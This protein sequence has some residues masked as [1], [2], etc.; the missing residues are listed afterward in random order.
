MNLATEIG[1]QYRDILAG[2]KLGEALE[3]GSLAP[4]LSDSKVVAVL[5]SV[6]ASGRK[7]NFDLY[8]FQVK[9]GKASAELSINNITFKE[10]L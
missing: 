7:W 5:T 6:D 9:I 3:M 2:M 1:K 4:G 8:W 10:N